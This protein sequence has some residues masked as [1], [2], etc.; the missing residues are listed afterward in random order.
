MG[1]EMRKIVPGGKT[2]MDIFQQFG[3]LFGWAH[4]SFIHQEQDPWTSWLDVQGGT[5]VQATHLLE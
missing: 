5:T 2:T 3:A 4:F 1:S